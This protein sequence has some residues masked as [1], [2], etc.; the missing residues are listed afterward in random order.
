MIYGTCYIAR[1]PHKS[2]MFSLY[3]RAGLAAGEARLSRRISRTG[4]GT[5]RW[6]SHGPF[7][8]SKGPTSRSAITSRPT[9][10]G[11]TAA[12]TACLESQLPSAPVR[13]EGV[14]RSSGD[15]GR[16]CR[17]RGR[18]GDPWDGSGRP[19]RA[20]QRRGR[21]RR[22]ERAPRRTMTSLGLRRK[23]R[24]AIAFSFA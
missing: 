19:A 24:S 3:G 14:A 16:R 7:D 13:A 23:A 17:C 10:T 9:G 5:A 12:L 2:R 11:D 21:L 18:P 22:R 4:F 1:A 20:L 6:P 15:G 8:L